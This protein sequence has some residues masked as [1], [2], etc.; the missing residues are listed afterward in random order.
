MDINLNFLRSFLELAETL[1][2][3]Q[4]AKNLSM[5][6][7]GLSRQIKQLEESLQTTLFLRDNKRVRLTQEGQYL[8]NHI[9]PLL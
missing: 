2:F 6:Q 9:T 7:P 8:K 1:N 5:A 3:S 4:A